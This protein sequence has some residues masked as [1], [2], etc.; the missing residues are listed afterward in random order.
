MRIGSTGTSEA[1][2]KS[3]ARVKNLFDK[4]LQTVEHNFGAQSFDAV[5]ESVATEAAVYER[6]AHY[7]VHEHVIDDGNRNGGEFYA[8]RT[9]VGS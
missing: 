8:S 2:Q 9:A 6:F 5:S 3:K 4:M 7:L 1:T